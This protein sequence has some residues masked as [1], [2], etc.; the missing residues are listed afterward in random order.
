MS[1]Y[2]IF[3]KWTIHPSIS[4]TSSFKNIPLG[5]GLLLL[6][7]FEEFGHHH[8]GAVALVQ[9]PKVFSLQRHFVAF[10]GQTERD[11]NSSLIQSG[12]W[13]NSTLTTEL[14]YAQ[15]RHNPKGCQPPP[16]SLL[17]HLL[18]VLSVLLCLLLCVSFSGQNKIR[19]I[20]N[21]YRRDNSARTLS[22]NTVNWVYRI[23]SSSLCTRGLDFIG[24]WLDV[25]F[26]AWGEIGLQK[27]TERGCT[28]IRKRAMSFMLQESK[29]TKTHHNRIYNIITEQATNHPKHGLFYSVYSVCWCWKMLHY[30]FSS[31]KYNNQIYTR[32]YCRECLRND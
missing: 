9:R 18:S 4:P 10:N 1:L 32:K 31:E 15:M 25:F 12:T 20:K 11:R 19:K 29:I 21:P 30:P 7:L 6:P 16:V 2:C 14:L 17:S 22:A 3:Q 27:K 23:S 5:F 8:F 24:N 26:P 28:S 13:S